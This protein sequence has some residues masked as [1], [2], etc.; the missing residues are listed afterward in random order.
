MGSESFDS[1]SKGAQLSPPL[2]VGGTKPPAR[3]NHNA[4]KAPPL[5]RNTA[6]PFLFIVQAEDAFASGRNLLAYQYLEHAI[7]LNPNDPVLW[8]KAALVA[9]RANE[10]EMASRLAQEGLERFPESAQLWQV[11]ALAQYRMGDFR[12]A[13][14]AARQA[15]S[16]DKQSGLSYFLVGAALHQQGQRGQ[17]VGYF[18][19]AA[20][21]EPRFAPSAQ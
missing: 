18:Q 21:L 3:F 14:D 5:N 19:Q 9:L 1:T 2:V 6:E 13:E 10:A 16:L 8:Q 12:G 17:A 4:G 11:A 7:F 20:R 15:I